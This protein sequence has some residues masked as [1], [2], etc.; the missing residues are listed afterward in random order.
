MCV[1][2]RERGTASL[3]VERERQ[4]FLSRERETASLIVER[5]RQCFLSKRESNLN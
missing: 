2:N 4:S 5:E 3:I 1:E